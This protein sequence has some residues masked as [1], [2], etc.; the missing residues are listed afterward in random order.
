MLLRLL[1]RF[2]S[3]AGGGEA[4]MRLSTI[5]GDPP[6]P[7]RAGILVALYVVSSLRYG[8][9]RRRRLRRRQVRR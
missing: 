3:G 8:R 1:S 7:V 6:A 9:R 2:D 5:I 4:D